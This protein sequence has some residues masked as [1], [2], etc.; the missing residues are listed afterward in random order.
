[1]PSEQDLDPAARRSLDTLRGAADDVP[2]GPVPLQDVVRQARGRRRR[3][4][5]GAAAATLAGV[6]AASVVGVGA[7]QRLTQ[8][9]TTA[10]PADGVTVA[11]RTDVLAQL[12][13][14][15]LPDG[16]VEVYA[17]RPGWGSRGPD[18]LRLYRAP[19]ALPVDDP[20]VLAR[21][22]ADL[23][24]LE[25]YDSALCPAAGS[26]CGRHPFP[27]TGGA[28]VD[29]SGN[30]GQAV[31]ASEPV[32]STRRVVEWTDGSVAFA[33]R[34]GGQ[35]P[36]SPEQVPDPL[37]VE[38]LLD[39]A[40]SVP[41]LPDE[42]RVGPA[43]EVPEP[44]AEPQ[45]AAQLGPAPIPAP[46]EVFEVVRAAAPEPLRSSL[47]REREAWV[48]GPPPTVRMRVGT[49]AADPL[50]VQQQA[51]P[52][53]LI[54]STTGGGVRLLDGELLAQ[55]GLGGPNVRVGDVILGVES[56]L[57]ADGEADALGVEWIVRAADALRQ[58]M[59]TPGTAV[60]P[61]GVPGPAPVPV[62]DPTVPSAE[63]RPADPARQGLRA[64]DLCR[65]PPFDQATEAGGRDPEPIY[66][67]YL[68]DGH[69]FDVWG[70]EGGT[71]AVTQAET[72][73]VVPRA[74]ARRY[75]AE[76]RATGRYEGRPTFNTDVRDPD[77]LVLLCYAEGRFQD[78]G[79]NDPPDGYTQAVFVVDAKSG[80]QLA[81]TK[82]TAPFPV[83]APPAPEAAV[84]EDLQRDLGPAEPR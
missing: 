16:F 34:T 73:Q 66:R 56:D 10:V 27:S 42:A 78:E 30:P 63:P 68:T 6:V 67:G 40:R 28:V 57:S 76:R 70:A 39:V 47:R 48:D 82:S 50:P 80:Q 64:D 7:L 9:V 15:A 52:A 2:L 61:R 24:V 3:R 79:A 1:M 13:P 81:L 38:A 83:H 65:T 37:P 5:Q 29:V 18:Y 51:Q 35:G 17:G 4:R 49:A 22:V 21:G 44:A 71:D 32:V 41:P 59:P 31:E 36:P 77:A 45:A 55:G 72:V 8:D 60:V 46:P 12:A 14:T 62:P 53:L 25:V 58:A 33:L 11:E 54:A 26:G 43:P 74:D 23:L 20:S 84:P 75:L 69:G 19:D